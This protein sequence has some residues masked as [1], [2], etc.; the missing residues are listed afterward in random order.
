M[1][2]PQSLLKSV[3]PISDN[4]LNDLAKTQEKKTKPIDEHLF[5]K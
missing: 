3:K 2:L 1:A 5:Y 4:Y